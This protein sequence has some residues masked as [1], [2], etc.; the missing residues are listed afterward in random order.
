MLKLDK[1]EKSLWQMPFDMFL[2]SDGKECDIECFMLTNNNIRV[3]YLKKVSLFK[4]EPLE[5]I[6]PIDTIKGTENGPLI[7]YDDYSSD[8]I[9]INIDS[10]YQSYEFMVSYSR[11]KSCEKQI[12]ELC[13][14]VEIGGYII[15]SFGVEYGTQ[16]Q[17]IFKNI[18]V[19]MDNP[20]TTEAAVANQFAIAQGRNVDVKHPGF[21]GQDLY[22]I[23]SNYSYTCQVEMM[24]CAQIMPLMY[25]QLNNIPM[26]RGAYQ[27]INVNHN[28]TPGNM[29]TTFKGVRIANRKIPMVKNLIT[30]SSITDLINNSQGGTQIKKYTPYDGVLLSDWTQDHSNTLTKLKDNDVMFDTI[31]NTIQDKRIIFNESYSSYQG[32]SKIDKQGNIIQLYQNNNVDAF[33]NVNP[34]LRK[35]LCCIGKRV[36]ELNLEY[37]MSITSCTRTI[38]SNSNSDHFIPSKNKER[39]QITY[40]KNGNNITY[41]DMGCA[42]DIV[43]CRNNGSVDNV[44]ASLPLFDLIAVEFIDNIKQLIWEHKTGVSTQQDSVSNCIHIASYGKHKKHDIFVAEGP[45]FNSVKANNSKDMTKAPTNLPPTFIRILQRLSCDPAKYDTVNLNNFTKKPTH[46]DLTRWC[47][48]LNVPVLTEYSE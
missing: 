22:Q 11:K 5:I 35:L 32:Y 7:S 23:Y 40:T 38:N 30:I 41:G 33:N 44:Y 19:N 39:E 25:F 24:G 28:I 6:I 29:S 21:E 8:V 42:V 26:F 14:D 17:S 47:K 48:E 10:I 31:N 43:G 3:Q 2:L 46:K 15:P 34:D 37:K 36:K 27:I 4:K 1:G 18:H 12:S 13:K 16:K 9:R 45:N 20:Q